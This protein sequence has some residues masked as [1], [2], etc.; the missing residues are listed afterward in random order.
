[1]LLIIKKTGNN[2]STLL[3]YVELVVFIIRAVC[4]LNIIMN[5]G[6]SFV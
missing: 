4:E 3:L 1:M 6:L 2:H 5:N